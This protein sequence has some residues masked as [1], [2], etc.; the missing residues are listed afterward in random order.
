M[1]KLQM[2]V[3]ITAESNP[4]LLAY[5]R[6]VHGA[7]ERSFVMKLLAERGLHA[8]SGTAVASLLPP[9][10]TP[11]R[12]AASTAAANIPLAPAARI[13]PGVYPPA[14]ATEPH[15]SEYR[16][17]PSL[18]THAEA[19]TPQAPTITSPDLLDTLNLGALNAAMARFE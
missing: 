1:D 7:R 10:D 12:A 2:T 19:T 9:L 11:P 5:L 18:L 16:P 4:E 8:H 15:L 13:A 14:T 6:G 17:E 3:T